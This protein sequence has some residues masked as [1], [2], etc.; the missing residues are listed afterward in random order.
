MWAVDEKKWNLKKGGKEF[1]M[2][3]DGTVGFIGI[4]SMER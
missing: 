1:E 2:E 3:R 4:T